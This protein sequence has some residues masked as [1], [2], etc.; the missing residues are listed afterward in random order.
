MVR[1]WIPRPHALD[2]SSPISDLSQI[3]HCSIKGLPV[4]EVVRIENMI[5]QVKFSL[6][7]LTTKEWQERRICNLILGLK[8]LLGYW[9]LKTALMRPTDH[10]YT[11]FGSRDSI[12]PPISPPSFVSLLKLITGRKV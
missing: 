7:I 5:S 6:D 12:T 9:I 11:L 8:R 1:Y 10:Q 4:R 2:P 3:S